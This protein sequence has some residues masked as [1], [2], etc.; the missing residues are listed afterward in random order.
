VWYFSRDEERYGDK[1]LHCTVKL[2]QAK[3]FANREEKFYNPKEQPKFEDKAEEAMVVKV[4]AVHCRWNHASFD[5]LNRLMKKLQVN[6]KVAL[7]RI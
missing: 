5:E 2:E 7:K 4:Q 6:W 3:C 1:L